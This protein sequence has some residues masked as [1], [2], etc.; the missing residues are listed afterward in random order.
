VAF[1]GAEDLGGTE[2]I[3]YD[4]LEFDIPYHARCKRNGKH[5]FV[6]LYGTGRM[7]EKVKGTD[8]NCFT[9][10]IAD[11][12]FLQPALIS[13]DVMDELS[14]LNIQARQSA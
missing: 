6:T 1:V 14:T 12:D 3:P 7:V 11:Y 2:M 5:A 4:K 10:D 8:P 13:A 9:H